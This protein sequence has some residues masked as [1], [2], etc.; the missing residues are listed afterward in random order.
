MM[1]NNYEVVQNTIKLPKMF[2]ISSG[3]TFLM[4]WDLSLHLYR[5]KDMPLLQQ[6]NRPLERTVDLRKGFGL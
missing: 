2:S 1:T 3:E 5:V 6:S 4:K